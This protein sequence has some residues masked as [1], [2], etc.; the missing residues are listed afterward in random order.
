MNWCEANRL[1][2]AEKIDGKAISYNG[3]NSGGNLDT[4]RRAQP[5]SWA[6]AVVHMFIWELVDVLSL[7]IQNRLL[8]RYGGRNASKKWRNVDG[9]LDIDLFLDGEHTGLKET[10]KATIVKTF[11]DFTGKRS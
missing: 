10:L 5:E 8:E 4:L 9:L 7:Q 6:T 3:W 1:R 11:D 2:C